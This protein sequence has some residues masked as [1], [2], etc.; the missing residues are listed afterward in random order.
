MPAAR[1]LVVDDEPAPLEIQKISDLSHPTLPSG[2]LSLKERV[3]ELEKEL[4]TGALEETR[5]VQTKAAK[6]LGISRRII[7][8]KMEKY[9]IERR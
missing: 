1:I 3:G 5:W 6:L 7:R 4:I 9:G 2:R 8:Y